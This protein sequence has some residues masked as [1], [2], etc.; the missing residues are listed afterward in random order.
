MMPDSPLTISSST[1]STGVDDYRRARCHR[2]QHDVRHA[3][4][5]GREHEQCG[6][7]HQT[8]NVVLTA[9][10][11]HLSGEIA[12]TDLVLEFVAERAVSGDQEMNV[13]LLLS[14]EVRRLR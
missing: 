6:G 10:Q 13:T 14:G 2:F 8:R 1:P 11:V 7:P 4:P 12:T 9:D 5:E 3:L